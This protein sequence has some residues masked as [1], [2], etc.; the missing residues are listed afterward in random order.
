MHKLKINHRQNN[1]IVEFNATLCSRLIFC[2]S[3]RSVGII[4]ENCN[5]KFVNIMHVLA[6][7]LP[8]LFCVHNEIWGL[9]FNSQQ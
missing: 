5:V 8:Q 3:L 6:D 7:L 1:S 2:N 9:K 4:P